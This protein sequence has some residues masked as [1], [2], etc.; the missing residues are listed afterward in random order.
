[1]RR[2]RCILCCLALLVT[3][4]GCVVYTVPE[5]GS[6]SH[7]P[8]RYHDDDYRDYRHTHGTHHRETHHDDYQQFAPYS[9]YT[10][11]SD[12]R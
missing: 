10:P 3:G 11:Y 8:R 2:T 1:M 7:Y 12:R 6:Y 9:P 4:S 5:G